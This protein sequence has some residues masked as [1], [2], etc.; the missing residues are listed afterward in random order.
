VPVAARDGPVC[1]RRHPAAQT[2]RWCAPAPA[3]A[4]QPGQSPARRAVDVIF[5]ARLHRYGIDAHAGRNTGRLALA[6]E[7]PASVLADL[8]GIG[9]S[10]AERWSH[11]AKRDWAAYVGQRAADDCKGID[12]PEPA[13]QTR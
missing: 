7:L 11:W 10:T 5:G 6:A 9:I 8:T 4:G 13:R 2:A 12:S 1:V 3:R